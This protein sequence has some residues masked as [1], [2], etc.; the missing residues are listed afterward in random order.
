MGYNGRSCVLRALCES[1]QYFY[2]KGSNM[3]EELVR[4]V[5]TLPTT[6]VLPFEHNDIL[7]YDGAHRKGKSKA[8][9]PAA[10][11]DCSFSLI[12]LALGEYSS[13]YNYM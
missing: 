2:K 9:C 12:D 8:F 10:Y 7:E 1:A 5:F 13:P 3:I 11:P 6:K 4:T